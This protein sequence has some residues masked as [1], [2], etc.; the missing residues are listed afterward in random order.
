MGRAGF[1][2][3]PGRS[4][5]LDRLRCRDIGRRQ[6]RFAGGAD[7]PV[8][9]AAQVDG[10][11]GRQAIGRRRHG[12]GGVRIEQTDR[13]EAHEGQRQGGGL[14]AGQIEQAERVDRAAAH[15]QQGAAIADQRIALLAQV[16]QRA[17]DFGIGEGGH[18]LGAATAG[19]RRPAVQVGPSAAVGQEVERAVVAPLRLGHRFTGAAGHPLQIGQHSFTRGVEA[20]CQQAGVVPGHGRVVP[21]DERKPPSGAV[22]AR[23]GHEVAVAKLHA[24]LVF[25]P[26]QVKQDD[27][28]AGHAAA[29]V[30]FAHGYQ[31]AAIGAGMAV[32]I[33]A[34]GR[35]EQPFAAIGRPHPHALVGKRAVDQPVAHGHPGRAAVLMHPAAQVDVGSKHVGCEALRTLCHQHAAALLGGASLDPVQPALRHPGI[36][37]R[38]GAH[39]GPF[40]AQRRR[41]GAAAQRLAVAFRRCVAAVV[42]H[43]RQPAHPGRLG[44][45]RLGGL[46][47][48]P[49]TTGRQ[50]S[51]G[52][53]IWPLL[54][55]VAVVIDTS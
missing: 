29:A 36:G 7:H 5:E 21:G 26:V 16:P 22:P 51:T 1:T 47:D 23:P 9:A 41:P 42:R 40:G 13:A 4:G 17:A 32:G 11:E 25:G 15:P 31:R 34:A 3:R 38:D 12:E 48:C 30:V 39:G 19:L 2:A 10:D 28:V 49:D 8:A 6:R 35:R 33:T 53:V 24:A 54:V 37:Q 14:P 44:F 55:S 50:T 27:G 46:F 45:Q 18:G 43:G 52:T 20:A